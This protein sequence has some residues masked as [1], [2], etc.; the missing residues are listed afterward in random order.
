MKQESEGL[1]FR[2]REAQA[3]SEDAEGI[4]SIFQSAYEDYPFSTYT[5]PESVMED[6]IPGESE[7][8][9]AEAMPG[10]EVDGMEIDEQ[11]VVGTGSVKPQ[12]DGQVAELG[13]AAIHEDFQGLEGADIYQ[14]ILDERC[15][16]AETPVVYTQPVSST[17]AIT[18][19]EHRDR[20]FAVVG[21]SRNKYPEVFADEGRE[22]VVPMVDIS[23]DFRY[24]DE[25]LEPGEEPEVYVTEDTEMLVDHVRGEINEGRDD[26][27]KRRSRLEG[28]R[29]VDPGDYGYSLEEKM[30]DPE[31]GGLASYQV[32][33]GGDMSFSEV[34]SEL[35]EKIEDDRYSWIGVEIDANHE[36]A[37]PLTDQLTEEGFMPEKYFPEKLSYDS[38]G[39]KDCIGLQ[40]SEEDTG[41]IEMINDAVEVA[42]SAGMGVETVSD[43]GRDYTQYAFL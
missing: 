13:S 43:T 2:I 7:V 21:V 23:S 28:D 33:P 12:E 31:E 24:M 32:L 22:T 9:V 11:R 17:H 14:T 34:S 5:E 35:E 15:S 39:P 40:Y 38:E 1:N 37:W 18:Q 4:A 36:Y 41:R 10:Q 29:D 30:D 19:K 25:R 20:G 26:N 3:T 8:I 16:R 6:V 42:K 27:L